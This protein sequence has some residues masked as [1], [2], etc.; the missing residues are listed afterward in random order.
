MAFC[1]QNSRNA[2][3]VKYLYNPLYLQCMYFI[4]S[5]KLMPRNISWWEPNIPYRFWAMPIFG[6][7]LKEPQEGC[8]KQKR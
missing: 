5:Q 6:P 2:L 8:I 1:G 3:I 4:I 7:I